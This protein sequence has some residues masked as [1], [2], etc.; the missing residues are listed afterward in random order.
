MVAIEEAIPSAAPP[1]M[2]TKQKAARYQLCL[3]SLKARSRKK[4]CGCVE[5]GGHGQKVGRFGRKSRTDTHLSESDGDSFKDEDNLK[6]GVDWVGQGGRGQSRVRE[7]MQGSTC[8]AVHLP[9]ETITSQR[10]IS[11]TK[12]MKPYTSVTPVWTALRRNT[13]QTRSLNLSWSLRNQ[14]LSDEE[15]TKQSSVPVRPRMAQGKEVPARG[16]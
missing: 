5:E 3:D 16:K 11:W 7:V 4:S 1:A 10:P 14:W 13:L 12:T 8:R 2:V 15:R 9:L 6:L